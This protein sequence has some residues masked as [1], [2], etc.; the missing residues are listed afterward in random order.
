[1]TPFV[2]G[3]FTN[4][5]SGNF[6]PQSAFNL[7]MKRMVLLS[8]IALIATA[9]CLVRNRVSTTARISINAPHAAAPAATDS[10]EQF[11]QR[12]RSIVKKVADDVKKEQ[13]SA[14]TTPNGNNAAL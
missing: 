14:Q 9:A 1:M 4:R 13:A 8:G 2:H 11:R 5:F 7:S 6:R 3:L 10:E 12:I